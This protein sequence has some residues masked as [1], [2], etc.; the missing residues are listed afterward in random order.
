MKVPDIEGVANH[1]VPESCAG[2]REAAGEA[3]TGVHVGQPLSDER[4]PIRSADAIQSA[5]GNTTCALSQAQA[6]S[7][8]SEEPG[9]RVR[10]LCGNREISMPLAASRVVGRTVKAVGL[11]R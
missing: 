9:M 8:A 10:L 3:L 1:G 5:E 6:G 4:L 2:R 7:A 11:N